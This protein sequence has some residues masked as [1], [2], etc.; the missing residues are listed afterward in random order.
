MWVGSGA[1]GLLLYQPTQ[2]QTNINS[3]PQQHEKSSGLMVSALVS[4][5]SWSELGSSSGWGHGV[6]FLDR[7]LSSH[8]ASLHPDV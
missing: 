7:V 4:G 8:S 3:T 5:T 2:P 1:D 6:V